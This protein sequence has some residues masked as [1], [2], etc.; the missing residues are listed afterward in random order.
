M[1][2]DS[3][4]QARLQSVLP[5]L[6]D[7]I[8][9]MATILEDEFPFRVTQGLRTWS[10]QAALYAQGRTTP[11][12]V[13]TNAAPG[14]SYHNFGMAVD[15]VPMTDL[16]P[17]WNVTHPTWQRLIQVGESVGLVSGSVWRTFPD[18]PHFQLTGSLPVSPDDDVRST[19]ENGGISAVWEMAGF[20]QPPTLSGGSGAGGSDV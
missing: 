4:S 9:Q 3:I 12:K 6:A 7:K 14:Y 11:G 5:E 8:A 10:E 15:L 19:F 16:G 20:T 13:V 17:D 1:S 2:L 18:F